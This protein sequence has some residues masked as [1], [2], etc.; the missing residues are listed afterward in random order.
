MHPV[1]RLSHAAAPRASSGLAVLFLLAACGGDTA[2][3]DLVGPDPVCDCGGAACGETTCGT[4]C[5]AVCGD[6]QIC[7]SGACQVEDTCDSA[8]L[9]ITTSA[10]FP[11]MAA[12]ALRVRYAV[13]D[14]ITEPPFNRFVLELNHRQ[15]WPNGA[16][17]GV[18]DLIGSEQPG[19]AIYFR[20][21]TACNDVD[22]GFTY[23]VDE[24]SLDV[25]APGLPGER[26]VGTLRGVKLRQVRIDRNTG[27][28]STFSNARVW[29]LGDV[30]IDIAVP[31][32]PV[33]QGS[34][35]KDGTGVN[36]GE[37]IRDFTLKNCLGQE[38]DL[39]ARCGQSKV[40]WFVASAGWCGAC[41]AFVPEAAAYAKEP[42]NEDVDLIVVLGE[43]RL[44]GQPSEAYCREYA[45]AKGLDP[46]NT[47]IDHDG[48]GSWPVLFDAINTYSGSSIGLPWNAVLDGGS[49][50][51]VWS[52]NVGDGD[53]FGAID[54]LM[55]R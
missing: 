31:E 54:A 25:K 32:L 34:C 44:G 5:G 14:V 46:E 51:Y 52:S 21:Q 33:S 28:I 50:T 26:F 36:V 35:V 4:V 7:A 24:G 42:G 37:N 45:L 1:I 15:L 17:P 53:L 38:I 27:A 19:G 2:S 43:D 40:T 23:I 49:M 6:G 13:S 20:G 8:G 47:F 11:R 12:G 3:A 39:H 29:C 22:C 30:V 55:G 16:A 48:R 41:E 18:H 10:A 9:A